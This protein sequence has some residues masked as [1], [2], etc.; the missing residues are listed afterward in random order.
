MTSAAIPPDAPNSS[1]GEVSTGPSTPPV[2]E[3]PATINPS[4]PIK[5]NPIF[6]LVRRPRESHSCPTEMPIPSTCSD[7]RYSPRIVVLGPTGMPDF[8]WSSVRSVEDWS[9]VSYTGEEPPDLTALLDPSLEEQHGLVRRTLDEW[10]DGTNRFNKPGEVFHVASVEERH[11]GHVRPEHRSIHR[12]SASWA[13]QAPLR[14]PRI[15][16]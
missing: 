7:D 11:R 12:R 8:Y 16:P 3:H 2:E 1:A 10:V 9:I 14:T 6:T 13:D 5:E 4:T 15:P